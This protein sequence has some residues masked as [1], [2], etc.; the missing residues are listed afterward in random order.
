MIKVAS[1]LRDFELGR[2][3]HGM[4]IKASLGSDVDI[5]NSLVHFYGSCGFWISHG[6]FL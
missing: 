2:G 3:F 5:I 6:G 1:E 4:V